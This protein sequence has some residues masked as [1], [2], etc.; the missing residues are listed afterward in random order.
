MGTQVSGYGSR[1]RHAGLIGEPRRQQSS[2]E[3]LFL[4]DDAGPVRAVVPEEGRGLLRPAFR[5]E[6]RGKAVH[7]A[8]P[9]LLFRHLLGSPSWREGGRDP[10][11]GAADRRK[12]QHR[13]RGLPPEGVKG[14]DRVC[15]AQS[16]RPRQVPIGPTALID[17]DIA[18]TRSA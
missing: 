1:L 13:I 5:P 16:A 11:R 2:Q 4:R 15:E 12:L 8:L 9:R 3:D 14:Q 18:F 10:R 6:V 7:A 17:D